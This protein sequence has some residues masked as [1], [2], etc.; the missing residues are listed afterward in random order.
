[1]SSEVSSTSRDS[2]TP[3]HVSP[4]L[5]R[6][7]AVV[8]S[9][10]HSERKKSSK[11]LFSQQ[12]RD[13][14][15]SSPPSVSPR[16]EK[17]NSTTSNL[18]HKR[19]APQKSD[20]VSS[21]LSTGPSRM[22]PRHTKAEISDKESKSKVSPGE[23]VSFPKS[24]LSGFRIPKHNK[25]SEQS[26]SQTRVGDSHV[27]AMNVVPPS[28][29]NRTQTQTLSRNE[30]GVDVL[31][32]VKMEQGVNT[33]A[34]LT[35]MSEKLPDHL[36]SAPAQEL[37]VRT[38][39]VSE[40]EES[41]VTTEAKTTSATQPSGGASPKDL[42]SLFKSIDNNTLHALAS[43]IQLALNSSTSQQVSHMYMYPQNVLGA[44]CIQSVHVH[45]C[46]C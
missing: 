31:S 10:D 38:E 5:Q 25:S 24:S 29:K 44:W 41:A 26:K 6:S 43:T 2:P 9:P 7:P 18:V 14:R 42:M 28:R 15:R 45:L 19:R 22:E 46:N 30:A 32:E 27:T 4:S 12:L 8:G 23:P 37:N 33:Q 3:V 39:Q 36:S 34:E 21:S 17:Y 11:P 35:T 40:V 1:M 13:P 16:D 20:K